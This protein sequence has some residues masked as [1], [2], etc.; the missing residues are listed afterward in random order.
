MAG[1]I[2]PALLVTLLA[3]WGCTAV[4]PD[5][6]SEEIVYEHGKLQRYSHKNETYGQKGES[7]AF[8]E[9]VDII[10]QAD[11][12]ALPEVQDLPLPS[13]QKKQEIRPYTGIIKNTT[14]HEVS[15][16]SANSNATIVIPKKSF[17][18]YTIW[19]KRHDLTAY[20]DGKPFYC[21][22][23]NAHP[24]NYPFMCKTYD[25]MAEIAEPAPPTP[26]PKAKKVRKKPKPKKDC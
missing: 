6:H 26:K 16:Y 10:K 22:R 13:V 23:I 1:K 7:S 5:F 15:V 24:K 21:L 19:G 8:L 14:R 11:P 3:C 25:F 4:P 9:A 20:R 18:E 17:I 12:L 2:L